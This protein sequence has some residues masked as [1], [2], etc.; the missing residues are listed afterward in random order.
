MFSG[1]VPN[2]AAAAP[3]IAVRRELEIPDKMMLGK[4]LLDYKEYQDECCRN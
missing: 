2:A 1:Q 4:R 3:R